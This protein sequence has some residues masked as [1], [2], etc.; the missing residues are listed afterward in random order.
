MHTLPVSTGRLI[1]SK[2]LVAM[3]WSI[4][5]AA[6]V[7][8]A[9]YILAA[10]EPDFRSFFHIFDNISIPSWD[11]FR[12]IV[13]F[14][15]AVLVSLMSS[16]LCL[17]ACMALSMLFNSHRVAISFAFFI[18]ATTIVQILTAVLPVCQQFQLI[19]YCIQHENQFGSLRLQWHGHGCGKPKHS[20]RPWVYAL[21]YPHHRGNRRVLLRPNALYAQAQAEPAII[22]GYPFIRAQARFFCV[23]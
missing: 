18:A 23:L 8:A 1:W 20:R 7:F 22:P 4:V 5:C 12:F 21:V 15:V 3:I 14:M 9:I 11:A 19:G 2:L 6:V 13:E 17:Y 10:R 16:I